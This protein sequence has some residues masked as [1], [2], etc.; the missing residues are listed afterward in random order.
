MV[1]YWI[2]NNWGDSCWIRKTRFYKVKRRTVAVCFLWFAS[3]WTPRHTFIHH[4]SVVIYCWAIFQC[5]YTE[6]IRFHWL[7]I[8]IIVCSYLYL[9]LFRPPDCSNVCHLFLI[10]PQ[11]CPIS[12]APPSWVFK[13]QNRVRVTHQSVWYWCRWVSGW[14]SGGREG[15]FISE[16]FTGKLGSGSGSKGWGWC[17]VILSW[18]GDVIIA[19]KVL[20][21]IE[22]A[23]VSS[24]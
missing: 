2:V 12:H 17:W 16:C 6:E 19:M 5:H 15:V 1:L 23:H 22:W 3:L 10:L 8:Q 13:C 4:F 18:D 9:C 11:L 14:A 7:K 24:L 21:M 20:T